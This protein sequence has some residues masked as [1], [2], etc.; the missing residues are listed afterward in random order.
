MKEIKSLVGTFLL[1]IATFVPVFAQYTGGEGDGGASAVSPTESAGFND[2]NSPFEPVHSFPEQPVTDSNKKT[3]SLP[4]KIEYPM[5]S[6]GLHKEYYENGKI[7]SVTNY[8][9]GKK[10]GTARFYSKKGRRTKE[11]YYQNDVMMGIKGFSIQQSQGISLPVDLPLNIDPKDLQGKILHTKIQEWMTKKPLLAILLLNVLAVFL[12]LVTTVCL[13]T[14]ISAGVKINMIGGMQIISALPGF[15]SY[16]LV[17]SDPAFPKIMTILFP[18]MGV[19]LGIG[20]LLRSNLA[21]IIT[22]VLTGFLFCL[23]FLGF[24][25]SAIGLVVSISQY[26]SD[27]VGYFRILTI[28]FCIGMIFLGV[29]WRA[30]VLPAVKKEFIEK[31]KA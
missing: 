28:P 2:S 10:E 30:L 7:K 13:M 18:G 19:I 9:G 16:P 25:A 24:V 8:V 6:D 11:I 17:S 20:I 26:A 31:P 29:W 15:L 12:S 5:A 23:V 4:S 27:K 14:P 22:L 3:S 21:R 1:L